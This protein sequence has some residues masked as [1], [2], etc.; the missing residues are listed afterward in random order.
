MSKYFIFF[1]LFSGRRSR[2]LRGGQVGSS[3]GI[4]EG[5]ARG[6]ERPDSQP[7]GDAQPARVGWNHPII[8][9]TEEQVQR[10]EA[11]RST[12]LS[13]AS[14]KAY[15]SLVARFVCYVASRDPLL[16]TDDLWNEFQRRDPSE[17]KKFA[18]DYYRTKPRPPSSMVKL[19]EIT[20]VFI[21]W[22]SGLKK[23][24]KGDASV[25]AAG[26]DGG[27]VPAPADGGAA[28]AV[29]SVAG[30]PAAG[31]DVASAVCDMSSSTYNSCRS[32]VVSLFTLFGVPTDNFDAEAAQMIRALKI[33]RSSAAHKGEI[34]PQKGK[35]PLSFE[36]YCG[37]AKAMIKSK[38][39]AAVFSHAVL[40]TMW[41]LM[42]RVS[43]AVAICKI[44]IWIGVVMPFLFTLP[45][46]KRIRSKANRDILDISMQTRSNQRFVL[47]CLLAYF[48]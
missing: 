37:I 34:R 41:N 2:R 20:T 24:R 11:L 6:E 17:W 26:A 31:D 35:T 32:A 43:N 3:E 7:V 16:L 1:H 42:S 30:A 38:S 39:S 10:R 5:G 33:T 46:K 4:N 15:S 8:P 18:R 23:R 48:S 21:D 19:R 13:E 9:M 28:A 47:F 27:A 40:T 14:M 12:I 44:Y 25:P 36:N 45:T 22:V 29:A